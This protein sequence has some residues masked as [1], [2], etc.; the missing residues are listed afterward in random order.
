MPNILY[1]LKKQND[2]DLMWSYPLNTFRAVSFFKKYDFHL[3]FDFLN[4]KNQNEYDL[5]FSDSRFINEDILETQKKPLIVYDQTDY[6]SC[7]DGNYGNIRSFLFHDQVKMVCK[8]SVYSNQEYHNYDTYEGTFH[9]N[10]CLNYAKKYSEQ[11]K[12][13]HPIIQ[14]NRLEKNQISKIQVLS[15]YLWSDIIEKSLMQNLKTD[16]FQ[17]FYLRPIDVLLLGSGSHYWCW[18]VKWHRSKAI[19][20]LKKLPNEIIRCFGLS[21]HKEI[22]KF[23]ESV[24]W[25]MPPQYFSLA[26][27]AKIVISP[28]GYGELSTR[29]YEAILCGNV[30]IKPKLTNESLYISTFPE[31]YNLR[32]VVYCEPDFSDLEL[33]VYKI[34]N[35]Y[36]NYANASLIAANKFL[37]IYKS[38]SPFQN[39]LQLFKNIL[40]ENKF[41]YF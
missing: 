4:K 13:C 31:I 29:D 21:G 36:D 7:Y 35:D 16:T 38:L 8:N 26:Q 32:N 22:P 25:P 34:L 27:K 28:W 39:L 23:R 15:H 14:H 30:I 1:S 2:E 17:D 11:P 19:D 5:I 24:V 40:N 9:G 33:Q 20:A 37:D 3:D 12:N 41:K 18:H 10:I 6:S